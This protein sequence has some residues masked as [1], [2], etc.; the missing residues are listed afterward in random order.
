MQN[1]EEPTTPAL[2]L[3]TTSS[4]GSN[5][6]RAPQGAVPEPAVQ[7][8]SSISKQTLALLQYSFPL[9]SSAATRYYV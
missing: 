1:N 3:F 4:V 7:R 8:L 9:Q 5:G 6:L 2:I